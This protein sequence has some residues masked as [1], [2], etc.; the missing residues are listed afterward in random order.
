[1]GIKVNDGI[2]SFVRILHRK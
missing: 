2:V 1:M